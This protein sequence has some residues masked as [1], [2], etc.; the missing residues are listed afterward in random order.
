MKKELKEERYRIVGRE[1]KRDVERKGRVERRK[2]SR[3]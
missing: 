2:N 3:F 1:R